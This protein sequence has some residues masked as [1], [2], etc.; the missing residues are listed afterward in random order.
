MVTFTKTQRDFLVDFFKASDLKDGLARLYH[1]KE[2]YK[3]P[4]TKRAQLDH[5]VR[6]YALKKDA[7][8]CNG[9]K[10]GTGDLCGIHISKGLVYG[11]IGDQSSDT[12]HSNCADDQIKSFAG[13]FGTDTSAVDNSAFPAAV[14]TFPVDSDPA[15][16]TFPVDS[17]AAV[18]TFPVDPSFSVDT[19]VNTFGSVSAEPVC[20]D[21]VT[22]QEPQLHQ[23]QP[24]HSVQEP[25]GEQQLNDLLNSFFSVE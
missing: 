11:S 13:L 17:D 1:F 9:R 4:A 20:F 2:S 23:V 24:L 5:A 21:W 6:C 25:L 15:V 14:D 7:T 8:R 22:K 3:K 19:H 10:V 16:D 18:D 12:L